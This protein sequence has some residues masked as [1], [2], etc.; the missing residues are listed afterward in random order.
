MKIN[1]YLV[2]L[3]FFV[4][5]ISLN[6]QKIKGKITSNGEVVPFANVVLEGER[7]GVSANLNGIYEI[8]NVSLLFLNNFS[9][10]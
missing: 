2:L 9:K 1:F 5:G 6:A 4:S 10:E 3:L 8:E 7:L